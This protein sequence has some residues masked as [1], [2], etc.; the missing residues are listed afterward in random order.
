[1]R[2]AVY[3]KMGGW[4]EVTGLALVLEVTCHQ[5]LCFFSFPG[6]AERDR[7]LRER[8]TQGHLSD[9]HPGLNEGRGRAGE[10]QAM[11]GWQK[12][13]GKPVAGRW[14]ASP[15][16]RRSPNRARHPPSVSPHP[17]PVLCR[18]PEL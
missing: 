12:Q 2:N 5:S 11:A 6:L 10:W 18:E 3:L 7:K 13:P 16:V 1:M 17:R 8:G 15:A 9:W 14:H 4:K